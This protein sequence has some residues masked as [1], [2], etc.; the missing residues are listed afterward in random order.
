MNPKTAHLD[1]VIL[2]KNYIKTTCI[3]ICLLINISILEYNLWKCEINSIHT[4]AAQ[5]PTCTASK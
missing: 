1:K 4:T 5:S 3:F 2:T